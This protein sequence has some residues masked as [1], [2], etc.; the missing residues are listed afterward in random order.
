ML[1]SG[2]VDASAAFIF[3]VMLVY[4]SAELSSGAP[5]LPM[6]EV[7]VSIPLPWS[8]LVPWMFIAS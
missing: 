7:I 1:P 2:S 8:S 6:V 5:S 4:A 3:E